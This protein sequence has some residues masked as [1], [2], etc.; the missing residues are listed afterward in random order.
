MLKHWLGSIA[1][2]IALVAG[3]C[4]WTAAAS[5]HRGFAGPQQTFGPHFQ[6]S[7]PVHPAPGRIHPG[8]RGLTHWVRHWNQVA[9]DASGLDHTPVAPGENRVFGEQFGP[10]RASR[11]M[12]IV[13]IAMFDALDAIY[14]GYRGYTNIRP[15]PAGAS[16]QAAIAQAA[17]NTLAA[18]FPSQTPQ[19]D[20]LLA[21][22][23]VQIPEGGA[24][25]AGISTGRRAAAAI[26]A[27]R[28]N[29]GSS[30]ADPN[31]GVD[32]F[33]NNEPGYWRQDPISLSTLALGAYWGEVRP[34]V[35]RSSSQFRFPKPPELESDAYTAAFNET[36]DLGGDGIMTPT[37]RTEEQTFIGVFWAYDGTPSLCAPPRMYNQI[38]AQ[39]AEL[40]GTDGLELARLFALV[41]VAMAD[42]AIA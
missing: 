37:I 16:A 4:G 3:M 31:F 29:D 22:E 8:L 21:D 39:I 26:L 11:A 10:C 13:H 41:N 24:K 6:P 30:R 32:Y 36:K 34:F 19:F 17:H 2:A 7:W 1:L 23:L 40:K 25:A 12:A 35:M 27:L 14:G 9:I 20:L 38:T 18:L 15:A 42:T 5:L 28:Q 33:P